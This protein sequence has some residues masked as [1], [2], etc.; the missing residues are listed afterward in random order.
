[1]HEVEHN[2]PSTRNRK[3]WAPRAMGIAHTRAKACS[4][5]QYSARFMNNIRSLVFKRAA[6]INGNCPLGETHTSMYR[7]FAFDGQTTSSMSDRADIYQD[8]WLFWQVCDFCE[9]GR[10]SVWRLRSGDPMRQAITCTIKPDHMT[11]KPYTYAT[12]NAR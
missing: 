2:A 7:C 4:R 11:R 8:S 1:M 5:M 10:I 12:N 6:P 3:G 9:P